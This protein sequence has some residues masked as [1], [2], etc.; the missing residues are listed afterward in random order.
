MSL[1]KILNKKYGAA[2]ELFLF[3]GTALSCLATA[4]VIPA[5]VFVAFASMK[6]RNMRLAD[7]G[8]SKADFTLKNIIT[9][10]VTACFYF[11]LFHF[12]I[13]AMVSK[14]GSN[15]IETIFG[16]K[17]NMPKL[18]LWLIASWVIAAFYEEIIFR[19]YL[20]NRMTDL[21]GNS[22]PAKVFIVV[23]AATAFGFAHHYQ[24]V[25]GMITSGFFGLFQSVIYIVQKRK[26]IVPV[27]A[28]GVFDTIGFVRLF[29]GM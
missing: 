26:L 9:G 28:H 20:V 27:I 22:L 7:T 24:G 25:R 17:G 3:F 6:I 10:M 18:I 15:A 8:L 13:D 11:I 21:F 1:Q 23:L 14:I 2:F 5:L 12:I 29:L 19:G 4:I 16:V